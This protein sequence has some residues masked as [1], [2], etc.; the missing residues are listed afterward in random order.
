MKAGVAKQ[1]LELAGKP[2]I[3]YALKAVEDS[4][5]IHECILVTGEDDMQ[6]MQQEIVGKYG[7]HKV[8]AIIPGGSERCFSVAN[9]MRWINAI[10]QGASETKDI[11]FI[12]DGARPFLTEEILERTL[13]AAKE[14]G[15]CVA[16]MPSKDTVKLMDENG[17][18]KETPDRK[19][20]WTVQTPQTFDRKLIVEAYRKF[21]QDIE[22]EAKPG[23]GMVTD[24]ASVVERYTDVKVK[25][26]EGA[27][28]N[29]KVTTPE[30]LVIAEA[31][32]MKE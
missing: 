1:F 8:T 27:Y 11:V 2:L 19:T 16:A 6:R 15:A 24:D 25:L 20:V 4:K 32:L 18:A 5:I 30:D 9:A 10:K 21:E 26:V 13:Q 7:F 31:F 28:T 3:Y 14:Y 23:R 22:S 12:H 17:F 29:I